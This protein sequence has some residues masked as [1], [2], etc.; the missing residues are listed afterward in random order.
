MAG[1]LAIV[2]LLLLV[3]VTAAAGTAVRNLSSKALGFLSRTALRAASMAAAWSLL[4]VLL[5][6][7]HRH[8]GL[9]VVDTAKHWQ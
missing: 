7:V 3:A 6:E 4:E 2:L 8:R 5:Q 9:Q 1:F